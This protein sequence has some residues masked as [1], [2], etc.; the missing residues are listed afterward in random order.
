MK[1]QL[2]LFAIAL[3][4]F[5]Q[6]QAQTRFFSTIK[7]E[8]EKTTAVRQLMKDLQENDSWYEQNKDR[9][10][11]SVLS[12][13]DFTGDSTKSLYKP[14]KDVPIDPKLW[15]RPSGDKNVVYN[16]YIKG[17]TIS[18]KPVF[19]ETFLLEDSLL[20]IKW[21]I[22]PDVR[23]I[24]G[25]DCRKAVGIL[26]DSIAVFAFYTDE[27]M[28]SGGPEG[29]NGLPGMILGMGIPRLHCTWFATK[30]EV[31]DINMNKVTPATKGKKTDRV[32]MEKTLKKLAAEWGTYGSKTMLNFI[33]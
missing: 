9:Y 19:E 6:S 24:A 13:Y 10:P 14:G 2:I 28:I 23:N 29:I 15:W 21:K 17:T 32:T 20:K 12:Y 30:V 3:A 31:F 16:D 27:L 33:I 8:Y 22:T 25:Y 26:H 7:V 1:K 5:W 18:Q 4:G 11:V